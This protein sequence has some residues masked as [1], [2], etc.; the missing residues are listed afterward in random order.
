MSMSVYPTAE[1]AELI[2]R[3]Y[4]K[5][6][7]LLPLNQRE[8]S[9][10]LQVFGKAGCSAENVARIERRAK[11]KIRRAL[12]ETMFARGTKENTPVE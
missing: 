3:A 4:I 1:Y 8:T 6:R 12:E 5:R 11:A 2:V 9:A 7:A 10:L